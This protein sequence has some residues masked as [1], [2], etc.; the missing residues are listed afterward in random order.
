MDSVS[1]S[2]VVC[3]I[4]CLYLWFLVASLIY[5]SYRNL[6]SVLVTSRR[7]SIFRN[8]KLAFVKVPFLGKELVMLLVELSGAASGC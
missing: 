2:E 5:F 4:A 3:K 6:S 7:V 8:L 1:D